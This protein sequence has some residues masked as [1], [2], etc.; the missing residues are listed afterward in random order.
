MG[1]PC[2]VAEFGRAAPDPAPQ[3]FPEPDTT[4]FGATRI[5]SLSPPRVF[6]S[7]RWEGS[8]TAV[9]GEVSLYCLLRVLN[10]IPRAIIKTLPHSTYMHAARVPH[11]SHH[12]MAMHAR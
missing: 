5:R 4:H 12:A 9:H 6:S 7:P 2:R 1:G 8:T 11:S 3:A 10:F